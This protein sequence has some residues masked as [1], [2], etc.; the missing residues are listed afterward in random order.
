MNDYRALVYGTITAPWVVVV[1]VVEVGTLLSDT[2][3]QP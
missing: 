2:L 1:V 3:T